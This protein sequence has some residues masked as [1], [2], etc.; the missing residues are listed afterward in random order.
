MDKTTIS[1]QAHLHVFV[2]LFTTTVFKRSIRNQAQA[3]RPLGYIPIDRNYYSQSQWYDMSNELKS[4]RLN[5]LFDTVLQSF[6]AA[7]TEG[8]LRVSLTLGNQT[9]LVN[10]KVPL[11]FIIGDIQG[12]DGICGRSAYYQIK[13][14]RICRMC[15]ATQAVYSSKQ[16]DNCKPLVMEEIKQLVLNKDTE[17]LHMLYSISIIGKLFLT[18]TMEVSQVG[19]L[20]QHALLKLSMLLK[21]A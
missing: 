6:R 11:A 13:A 15:D 17:R 8:S 3:W 14:R 18:L 16:V 7:Q 1:I 21:M 9:K 10:L 4:Q 2:I 19:F 5:I 20:L 12:G